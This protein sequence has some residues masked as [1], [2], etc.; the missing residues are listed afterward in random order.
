METASSPFKVPYVLTNL[1]LV[2]ATAA[3]VGGLLIPGLYRNNELVNLTW[4]ANDLVTLVLVIPLMLWSLRASLRGSHKAQ[5]IWLGTLWYTLYNYIFYVYG[6]AFNRFFL[7]YP[8]LFALS[9]YA[10]IFALIRIDVN[11]I[12]QEFRPTTPVKGISIYL[13]AFAALLAILWV[14]QSLSFVVTGNVPQSILQTEIPTGV[15]FGTDLSLALPAMVLSG[16]LLWTRRPWGYVLATMVIFKGV[17]YGLVLLIASIL[18]Y[19]RWGSVDP[20]IPLWIILVIGSF[21]C[22]GLLLGNMRRSAPRSKRPI[23][24]HTA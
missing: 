23:D 14:G 8:T 19:L 6:T 12:S 15:V 7:F 11:A 18:S 2:L 3:T 22:W 4:R 17:T 21:S 1:I 20:T 24:P 13:I 16:V 5:L 10:L 9:L